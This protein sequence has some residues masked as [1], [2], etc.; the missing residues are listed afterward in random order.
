MKASSL[1]AFTVVPVMKFTMEIY[2]L[3]SKKYRVVAF[4]TDGMRLQWVSPRYRWL[5]VARW[6][7][8]RDL[9]A[10]VRKAYDIGATVKVGTLMYV[11]KK[12]ID[13]GK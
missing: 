7:G 6:Q 9:L 10:Y 12:V 8:E 13:A 1:G 11:E 4:D 5:W 2:R 3:C